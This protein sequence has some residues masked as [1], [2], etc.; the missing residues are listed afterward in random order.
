MQID[1]LAN[2]DVSPLDK[3]IATVTQGVDIEVDTVFVFDPVSGSAVRWN[4]AFRDIVGYSDEEIA[5][6]KAPHSYYS[7][8]D[9]ERAA[10]ATME[11][12]ETGETVLEMHLICKDGSSVP[13][14]YSASV[15]KDENGN[16]KYIISIGKKLSKE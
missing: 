11:V 14:T 13:Y 12:L 4:Q 2:K 9:L 15:F 7:S 5:E 6:L 8:E 1:S 16:P 10:S 3:Y